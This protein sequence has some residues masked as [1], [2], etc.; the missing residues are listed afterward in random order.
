MTTA[1]TGIL[2]SMG[3][4]K[5]DVRYGDRNS[6]VY[7]NGIILSTVMA[8]ATAAQSVVAGRVM[9]VTTGGVLTPGLLQAATPGATG[10]QQ[11]YFLINGL[12]I[13]TYP[14]ST[15][16]RGMPG[17]GAF[18]AAGT[19][20]GGDAGGQ[21]FYGIPL[22]NPTTAPQGVFATIGWKSAVELSTTEFDTSRTYTPGM[23]LTCL[24]VAATD[25][26]LR[27]RVRDITGATDVVIGFVAPAG[28]Y[29]VAGYPT[30]AFYPTFLGLAAGNT[31]PVA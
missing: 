8:N 1:P 14:D 6:L 23:A 19:Y 18:P 27:G 21:P 2:S 3:A 28:V 30:L 31:V 17:Q 11:P 24:S 25:Q 10:G 7:Y 15:R 13:N 12:D 5:L 16:T 26:T 9:S 29:N 22:N 4:H 20:L